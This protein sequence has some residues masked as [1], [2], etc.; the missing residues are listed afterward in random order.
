MS[1]LIIVSN[2]L[3]VTVEKR[4][5]V[6]QYKSSVGGLAT[7]L[8]AYHSDAE[9]VWVGWP[10]LSTGRSDQQ[11]REEVRQKLRSEYGC[12]PVYLSESDVSDYYFGFSNRTLWP[13]FHHFVESV[14]YDPRHWAAYE[15]VNRKFADVVADSADNGDTIW[16]QD[17]QLLLLPKMLRERLPD[18]SIGFFLH[19][20]FPGYDAFR[21][22]PWRREIA[23]GLLGSDLI[24]FHTYDYARNFLTSAR[25]IIGCEESHGRLTVE[26]GR[27]VLVD[28]FP[29]GID[30]HHYAEGAQSP[31]AQREAKRLRREI[32]D[33]KIVL[34]VDRLDYTKGIPGRLRTFDAFLERFPEW[35][36]KVSFVCVAV[37]SRTKVD[38][39]RLLKEEVD[40]LV[41]EVNG[42]WSTVDWT[43]VRYLYRSLPFD[44]LVGLYTASDIAFVTPLRDGMNLI[45]KEYAAA[46]TSAEGVLILSEMAG[47]AKELGE[48]LL[49]NPNDPNAMVSVLEQ[50][51]TLPLEE[52]KARMTAIRDRVRRYDIKRWVEDFLT[53]LDRVKQEQARDAARRLDGGA[54]GKLLK[55]FGASE[56]RVL[57]LDYDGTLM[58]FA[59]SPDSVLPDFETIGIIGRLS[60][61]PRNRVVLISGRERDTLDRWLGTLPIALVAEHGMWLRP[62]RSEWST[63]EPVTDEWKGRVRLVLEMFV[64]RTPGSFIEEKDFSLVWHFRASHPDLAEARSIELREML[65]PMLS[66]LGLVAMEGNKVVEIKRS[67][68][69]KGRAAHRWMAEE[70]VDFVLAIGDDRTDEDTFEAAPEKAWTIKV[71]PGKTRAAYSLES[72][73]EARELLASLVEVTA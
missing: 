5:G 52:R 59:D 71:G 46:S 12:E 6:L 66:D 13:L 44:E 60:A 38:E 36:G 35:R 72:V 4:R 43:P 22:L 41:G 39:Y 73:N 32:G 61:D 9:S 29:M 55:Q 68:I 69:N 18:S 63:I 21:M 24:G 28:A 20:P 14:E 31:K 17:Y 47:A 53:T 34:S 15:R 54:R 8:G 70:D 64:D 37:P 65:A 27:R 67:E 30:F 33:N 62:E 25:N 3:P 50:A 26:G 57:L 23:E 7:G 10:A 49:V 40:R 56:H 1:R 51:L 11:E 42:R 19:I 16:V 48:A 2:R 58:P 45:A